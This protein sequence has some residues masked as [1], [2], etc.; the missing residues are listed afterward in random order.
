MKIEPAASAA[1]AFFVEHGLI[2]FGAFVI[3]SMVMMMMAV[4]YWHGYKDGQ[5]DKDRWD[6]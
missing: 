6:A 4:A 5:E 2:A 1:Q 3:A